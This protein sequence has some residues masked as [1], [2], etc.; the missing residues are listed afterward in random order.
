MLAADR[1]F[2]VAIIGSGF[3]GSLLAWVLASQG[4]RVIVIDAAK[5]PRFAIGESSTPIADL[6]LRHI[7]DVYSLPA[8]QQLSTFGGW[9]ASFPELACGRKRGFSYYQHRKGEAFSDDDEHCRSMMAAASADDDSADTHWY[10]H[11]V[12]QFFFQQAVA[13][14]CDALE[15]ATVEDIELGQTNKLILSSGESV[16]SSWLIDASGRSGVVANKL[17]LPSK[18]SELRTNTRSVFGHFVGV[19]SWKQ[20]CA[21]Q[22]LC[23]DKDPFDCDD[24]AQHHLL[25]DGWIWMLRFNND[26]TSVGWTHRSSNPVPLKA[27]GGADHYPSLAKLLDAAKL[28][29]EPGVISSGRLQRL[30]DPVV[31]HR[32]LLM[33]TA[34]CT[35][36]PLHSTGIAHGVSGVMRVAEVLLSGG[37]DE[38]LQNYR[39]DVIEEAKLIDQLVSLSYDAMD[40]FPRFTAA[41][42]LYF[43]A[44]IAC[45]EQIIA[46]QIPRQFWNAGNAGFLD[47]VDRFPQLTIGEIRTAIEPW[48]VAGLMDPGAM[49]RYAYTATK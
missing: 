42:M 37:D 15:L 25:D 16:E 26:V 31:N 34:A 13:A 9:Q 43:C 35:I 11:D 45:E 30:Y 6:L 33:P 20:F 24:S 47:V 49:N 23:T 29:S 21:E 44:A 2:D 17:S 7:G 22:E 12:D 39:R 1:R 46:G 41:C 10:R 4:R 27:L 18:T 3:S 14:G 38:R 19:G 36:D 32:C 8:L 28:I 48:N 40:D 5:H